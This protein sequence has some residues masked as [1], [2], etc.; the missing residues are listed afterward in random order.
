[1]KNVRFA[2]GVDGGGTKTELVLIGETGE[3][4]S[5]SRFGALNLN[6]RSEEEADSALRGVA[7]AIRN[8]EGECIMLCVGA[9]GAS[10]ET[11]RQKITEKL[12][13][14]GYEGPL[15]FVGDQETAL[16]AAH[17]ANSGAVLIAGTG[18]ICFG[19]GENGETA[20]TGGRGYRIDDEGSGYAIGRDILSAV[21]REY[22]G[23]GEKTQLSPLVWETLGSDRPEE[24]IRRLYAKED[25]LSPAAFAP[26]LPK[27]L[28]QG[29]MQ[30]NAI[31]QKA[32]EELFFLVKALVERLSL[33]TGAVALAG[34]ILLHMDAV[35]EAL[36]EK[37]KA[38]YPNLKVFPLET[39]A[40]VGAA[41][42][43]LQKAE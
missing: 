12:R 4:L 5:T 36:T 25:A 15:S 29:D 30:A 35:R 32:V 40:S 6:S 23:R 3:V 41:R 7:D 19:R 18:S 1:M 10:N 16:F 42:M 2:A 27:A 31:L 13:L 39:P 43:A 38:E 11:L 33:E 17:G 8:A 22:D 9:A 20:R 34:G 14:F 24:L 26:L 37:L 28:A 21:V